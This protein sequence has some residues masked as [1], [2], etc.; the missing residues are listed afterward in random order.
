MPRTESGH[1]PEAAMVPGLRP[2][3]ILRGMDLSAS[4]MRSVIH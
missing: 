4:M 2:G 3:R 1:L